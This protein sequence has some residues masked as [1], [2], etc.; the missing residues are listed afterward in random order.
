MKPK[1]RRN[2][3]TQPT[4]KLKLPRGSCIFQTNVGL[5]AFL[6]SLGPNL[7]QFLDNDSGILVV[8]VVHGLGDWP[9]SH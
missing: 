8:S 5:Q 9:E 1:E 3:L 7:C 2:I 4:L 6:L